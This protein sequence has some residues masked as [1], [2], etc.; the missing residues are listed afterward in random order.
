MRRELLLTCS[1]LAPLPLLGATVSIASPHMTLTSAERVRATCVR[2]NTACTTFEM[3]QFNC[4]CALNGAQW[5]PS[6]SITAHPLMFIS[7]RMYL[8]HEMEHILDFKVAMNRHAEE[9]ESNAFHS[10]DECE[11]FAAGQHDAFPG[12]L[13]AVVRASTL[14]RDRGHLLDRQ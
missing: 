14:R 9:I 11:S 2:V 13:R 6:A 7:H 12:V 1:L 5:S 3:T 10:R 8:R 4:A